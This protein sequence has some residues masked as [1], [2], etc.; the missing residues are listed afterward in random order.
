MDPDIEKEMVF[1][2]RDCPISD[3]Y[4]S[5]AIDF[6]AAYSGNNEY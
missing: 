6:I 3:Q 4:F 2:R 1:V 5:N